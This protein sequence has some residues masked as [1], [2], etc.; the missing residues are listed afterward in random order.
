MKKGKPKKEKIDPIAKGEN[1]PESTKIEKPKKEKRLPS[2]NN[3]NTMA[4]DNITAAVNNISGNLEKLIDSTKET[5]ET[6]KDI[7]ETLSNSTP[8][9]TPDIKKALHRLADSTRQP[10]SSTAMD[11]TS[12]SSPK[13]L[14]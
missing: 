2:L 5:N 8:T 12:F 11:R 1:V 10:F 6:L 14:R 9:S 7:K 4:T 13:P 3:E